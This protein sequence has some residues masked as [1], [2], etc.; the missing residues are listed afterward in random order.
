MIKLRGFILILFVLVIHGGARASILLDRVVAVVNK[1]VITWS[2]LYRAMEFEASDEMKALKDEEKR[3]IFKEN[4]GIFLE[5][6][7]DVKLQLQAAK[8]LGIDATIEEVN[9]A[10]EGIKK[11]YSLNEEA[12]IESLRKEGFILEGYK[13]KL[14]EQITLSKVVSQQV[15]G[16]IVVSENEVKKYIEENKDAIGDGEGYRVKQIFFK[17]PDNSAD[18]KA[19]EEKANTVL[20]RVKAGED[21]SSLAK[22]YSDDPA[23]KA[24]GDLGFIKKAHMAREFIDVVSRMNVGDVSQ[25]FWTDRGLHIVKLEEKSGSRNIDELKEDVRNKLL[26]KRFSEEYKNWIRG[27]REKA[28]IEIRL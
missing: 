23:G 8:K 24:G 3:K 15:R 13:K 7:I 26:E 4:E 16:K 2:D 11:K 1:E 12:L 25:P 9:E 17:R 5:S 14:A 18:R 22:E 6:L 10:I 20:Q 28:Y 21:F 19:T 27:L